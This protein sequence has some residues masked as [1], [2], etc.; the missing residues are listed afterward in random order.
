MAELSPDLAA[1]I[2]SLKASHAENPA[3][4]FMPLASA[5]REAG[6]I[7]RAEELL[8]ENLKRHPG[9]LSAHVLL[10]RCLADRGAVAEA[11]NEFQY[12]LSVDP[13]NLIALRTLGDMASAAGDGVEARRWYNELLAVDPMNADARQSLHLLD[14]APARPAAPAPEP[15]AQ[16]G[17][18]VVNLDGAPDAP[19]G[20]P[21]NFGAW[22]EVS[23]D[24]EPVSA[25]EAADW[26]SDAGPAPAA[27]TPSGWGD[28]DLSA[29]PPAA[30]S[31]DEPVAEAPAG[32]GFDALDFGAVD[33]SAPSGD[34]DAAADPDAT[35]EMGSAEP[36]DASASSS[37]SPFDAWGSLDDGQLDAD[38][39]TPRLEG[40]SGFFGDEPAHEHEEEE[41][42][43]ETMAELYARQGFLDRAAEVYRELIARRGAEPALVRRLDELEARAR[44][45][46]S[47]SAPA[48]DAGTLGLESDDLDFSMAVESGP[49]DWLQAVDAASSAPSEPA[50]GLPEVGVEPDLPELELSTDLN[51]PPADVREETDAL[52]ESAS[53]I[54]AFASADD[55]GRDDSWSAAPSEPVVAAN[56]GDTFADSFSR[57]FDGASETET[58]ADVSAS[59]TDFAAAQADFGDDDFASA[60]TDLAS[61]EADLAAAPADFAAA[62]AEGAFEDDRAAWE[63]PTIE[64]TE[65]VPG[66]ADQLA[67]ASAGIPAAPVESEAAAAPAEAAAPVAETGAP[68]IRAYLSNILT[69][70]PGA[71]PAAPPPVADFAPPAEEPAPSFD[72]APTADGFGFDA[73]AAADLP[74][75]EA[76]SI[77]DAPP[78]GT[79]V[80]APAAEE[81]APWSEAPAAA[82]EPAPWETPAAADEPAPWEAPATPSAQGDEPWGAPAASST[83]DGD[84]VADELP[85]VSFDREPAAEAPAPEPP[86]GDEL[87]PWDTPFDL[88]GE[89]NEAP[90]ADRA[91]PRPEPTVEESSG[92]SFEDFFSGPPAPP[93]GPAPT[94]ALES[95]PAL[96]PV[97]PP[98]PEPAPAPPQSQAPQS[99]GQGGDDD[100]DLESFQAWLQSLKR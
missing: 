25:A 68:S 46:G 60:D 61:A 10:G 45:Q 6:E 100:E 40:L 8:R 42:V 77:E 73:P 1:R 50:A 97:F 56:T 20:E 99:G 75:G 86:R 47:A 9:Y 55:F 82:D 36:A 4:F 69:W 62:E 35:V 79:P 19:G 16:D 74:A 28:P 65:P 49:P 88:A 22:G 37:A 78:A 66:L 33:F 90:V 26:E 67:G 48:P 76:P 7:G 94:P 92:F 3:R 5:Y 81:A 83:D 89:A 15:A 11:R 91:E 87:M 71:R 30:S 2:E 84:E 39:A 80:E 72:A 96:E 52:V 24:A 14:H 44:E 54:D 18:G 93:A 34:E 13:Q 21:A 12:V 32:G 17:F 98:E 29:S 59:T 64:E 63:P 58:A 41:V 57:G 43:T 95:A 27:E 70:R 51:A 31:P 23:L 53:G 38:A 85:W